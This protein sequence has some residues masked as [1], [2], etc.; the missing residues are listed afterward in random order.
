MALIKSEGLDDVSLTRIQRE[1]QAM[2]RLGSHPNIATVF[3]LRGDQTKRQFFSR[4]WSL[5]LD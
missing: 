4:C 1:A 5:I 3:D 2:C